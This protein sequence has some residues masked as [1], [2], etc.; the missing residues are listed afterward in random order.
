MVRGMEALVLAS[1]PGW[2]SL[3]VPK[4]RAPVQ[5]VGLLLASPLTVQ[6]SMG[7]AVYP[8]SNVDR[9]CMGQ[10]QFRGPL[11]WLGVL[12]KPILGSPH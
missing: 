1:H 11:F 10:F 8:I 6:Y 2:T 7:V 4:I 12:G 9:T 5:E 3:D